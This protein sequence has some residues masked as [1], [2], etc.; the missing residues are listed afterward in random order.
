MAKGKMTLELSIEE[1]RVIENALS[2]YKGRII[3]LSRNN[4]GSYEEYTKLAKEEKILDK[5]IE[6]FSL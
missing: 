4:E 6:D 2:N 1:W 5:L 3:H